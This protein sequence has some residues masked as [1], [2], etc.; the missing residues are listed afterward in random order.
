MRRFCCQTLFSQKKLDLVDAVEM[1]KI[2]TNEEIKAA[3]FDIDD[4]KAPGPDGF[5]CKIF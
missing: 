1:V 3:L 2:V 4:D 5:F